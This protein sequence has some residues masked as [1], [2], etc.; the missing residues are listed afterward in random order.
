MPPIPVTWNSK[1]AMPSASS[2]INSTIPGNASSPFDSKLS[3]AVLSS[4]KLASTALPS[5]L[6]IGVNPMPGTKNSAS[7]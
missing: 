1:P 6:G 3:S 2:R 5:G 4:G 7:F